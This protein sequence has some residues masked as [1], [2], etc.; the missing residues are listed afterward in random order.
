MSKLYRS[1]QGRSVD[2]EKLKLQNELVPAI[3]NM[4]VNARG[5]EL[6]HDGIIVRTREEVMDEVYRSK[7]KAMNEAQD[8]P[9]P[10]KSIKPNAA[11][12][13]PIPTSS[14]KKDFIPGEIGVDTDNKGGLA[15]AVS[16]AKKKE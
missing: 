3:G 2:I 9:I 1:A 13:Q 4:R 10:N 15:K 11:P 7:L 5:D 16:R 12:S 8:G 6:G 14:K